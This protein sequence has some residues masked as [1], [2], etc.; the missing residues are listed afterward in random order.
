MKDCLM[1]CDNIQDFVTFHAE[2]YV[3][4]FQGVERYY[5]YYKA[6]DIPNF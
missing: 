4:H 2:K 1:E 3:F 5:N 6:V